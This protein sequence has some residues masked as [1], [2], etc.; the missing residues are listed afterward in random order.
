[1]Q[2]SLSSKVLERLSPK[3]QVELALVAARL[4]LPFW[5]RAFPEKNQQSPIVAALEAVE[6]FCASGQLVPDT[7]ATAELAYRTVSSCDLPSGDIQRFSGF[8]I[9]H[10]AMAPWLLSAGS[11]AKAQ[12]NAMVAINYSE[13]IHS[14]AGRLAELEVALVSRAQE[15]RG[16]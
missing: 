6:K 11:V 16:A 2:R 4:A 3:A 5:Q 10:L 8:S 14:W 7:K 13:S 1:M 15:L 9:A 12:H